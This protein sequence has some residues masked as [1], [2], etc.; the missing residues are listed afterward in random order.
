MRVLGPFS[1]S[2]MKTSYLNDWNADLLDEYYKRWKQDPTLVDPS[3][4]AFFEGFELGSSPAT[5]GQAVA[6]VSPARTDQADELSARVDSLVFKY[7]ILGHTQ[8]AVDPLG[9]EKPEQSAFRFR[10]A[11]SRMEGR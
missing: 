11:I 8:A 10:H 1:A 9:E 5:N 7:R 2:Y 6:A 4:S 3:W